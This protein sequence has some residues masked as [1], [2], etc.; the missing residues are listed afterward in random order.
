M[1]H[2]SI[3]DEELSDAPEESGS[4]AGRPQASAAPGKAASISGPAFCRR[5]LS[6]H[7]ELN[8]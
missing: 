1:K 7:R 5:N 2:G 4:L 8:F 3:E 6:S